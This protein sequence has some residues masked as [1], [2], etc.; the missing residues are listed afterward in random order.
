MSK[1]MGFNPM[2]TD[3]LETQMGMRFKNAYILSMGEYEQAGVTIDVFR[4][5][6]NQQMLALIATVCSIGEDFPESTNDQVIA[7][8]KHMDEM[9][10]QGKM[11]F[12]DLLQNGGPNVG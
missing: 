9:A 7:F 4:S 12:R 5:H 2:N 8:D 1:K 3:F 6:V 11:M 10:N